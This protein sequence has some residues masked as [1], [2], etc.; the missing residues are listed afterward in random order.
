MK[1]YGTIQ[2]SESAKRN[3]LAYEYEKYLYV[4]VYDI[5]D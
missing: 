5:V 2:V 4:R 1:R 3:P